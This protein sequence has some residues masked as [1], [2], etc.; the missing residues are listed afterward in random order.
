MSTL[1]EHLRR[2]LARPVV[3]RCP[4]DLPEAAI[5]AVFTPALELLVIQ[6][7]EQ[8]GDPWSGHLALP[9]GRREPADRSLRHTAMRETWEEL[10]LSLEGA[11]YLGA[12]DPVAPLM[13]RRMCVWPYAFLLRQEPVPAPNEEVA[14]VFSVPL[15][16]LL[17]GEGRRTMPLEWGGSR[18]SFPCVEIDG[19]CLWGLTL[20]VV[21]QLLDRIERRDR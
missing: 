11:E 3:A 1:L 12:L 13:S 19:R 2:S 16:R 21:D 10:G 9:G 4:P 18:L 7:A 14:E 20:R 17:A 5:A 6:R 15:A 8:D